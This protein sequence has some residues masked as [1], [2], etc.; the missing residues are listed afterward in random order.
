MENGRGKQKFYWDYGAA[1]TEDA[2][3]GARYY[4]ADE[5]PRFGTRPS[6]SPS[7]H[8]YTFYAGHRR[9]GK[10]PPAVLPPVSSL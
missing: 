4:L 5:L 10:F 3:R 2:D 9:P 8:A 6:G 7:R 1:I